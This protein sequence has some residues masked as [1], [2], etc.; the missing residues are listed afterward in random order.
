MLSQCRYHVLLRGLILA[1]I[2][3]VRTTGRSD[4]LEFSHKSWLTFSLFR[5]FTEIY[6]KLVP[7]VF[8]EHLALLF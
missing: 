4:S 2:H 1:M 7:Q 5:R 3:S 6:L 8:E